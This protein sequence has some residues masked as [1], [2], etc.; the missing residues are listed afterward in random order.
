MHSANRPDRNKRPH[1]RSLRNLVIHPKFQ[2]PIIITNL[3]VL[4]VFFTIA[5]IGTQNALIDL[6]PAAGLSGMES[7]FF[8][9]YVDYQAAQIQRALLIALGV[10]LPLTAGITLIITHRIA[11]PLVRLRCFFQS[12]VDGMSPNRQLEFRDGDFL[13]EMEPLIS[14][15]IEKIQERE[16]RK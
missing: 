11:G 1:L 10:G 8:R 3:A 6:K 12:I 16:R 15:A 7:E 9:K 13:R 5:W 14:S 2:L 4:L